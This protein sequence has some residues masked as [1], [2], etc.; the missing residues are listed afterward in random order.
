MTPEGGTLTGERR[1]SRSLPAALADAEAKGGTPT[2]GADHERYAGRGAAEVEAAHVRIPREYQW[3]ACTPAEAKRADDGTVSPTDPGT[4]SPRLRNGDGNRE[5]P[6]AHA[7]P[8]LHPVHPA[9]GVLHPHR[10][11]RLVSGCRHRDHAKRRLGTGLTRSRC[12]SRRDVTTRDDQ[13]GR[14][15]RPAG[16]PSYRT[17]AERDQHDDNEHLHGRPTHA[18]PSPIPTDHDTGATRGPA[19]RNDA[20]SGDGP[21]CTTVPQNLL[22]F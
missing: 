19:S 18:R 12:R 15:R 11:V 17:G 22:D 2:C 10:R 5:P 6:E 8:C 9:P 1:L 13:R 14:R 7:H 21:S 16:R 3:G 20:P 4:R